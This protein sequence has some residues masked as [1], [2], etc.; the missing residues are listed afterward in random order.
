MTEP[1]HRNHHDAGEDTALTDDSAT[2]PASIAD[3]LVD[4][5]SSEA[6]REP[7][8]AE[9]EVVATSAGPDPLEVLAEAVA[10]LS[11]AVA[12]GRRT[13]DHQEGLLHKMHDEREQ[14]REA[15]RQRQRDPVLRD[16]IQLSDTCL[17][18]RRQWYQRSDVSPE[19]A[20]RVA[21]ALGDVAQDVR[22]I[23]ER[24]GVEDFAPAVGDRFVRSE[25]KAVGSVPAD[26]Q[27]DDGLV[28]EVRRS[29][30]RLGERVL[31]FSEVVVARFVPGQGVEREPADAGSATST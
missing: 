6:E 2:F 14:L 24:Q 25:A 9:Q 3:D 28:A 12:T 8:R 17:R 15:E 22:L 11:E 21:D 5:T 7:D 27:A 30:Y 18:N 26:D 4:L 23:L 29:G 10:S 19:T 31:R 20:E 1:A 16:L 13:Q